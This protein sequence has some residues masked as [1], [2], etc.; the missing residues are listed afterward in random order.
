[1]TMEHEQIRRK[2]RQRLEINHEQVV[3][4]L[5]DSC[6][7]AP[8]TI[9]TLFAMI[10]Q[11][12]TPDRCPTDVCK[13]ARLFRIS[14]AYDD[15]LGYPTMLLL[16]PNQNR[17]EP[18]DAEFWGQAPG[19]NHLLNCAPTPMLMYETITISRLQPLP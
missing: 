9:S 12:L 15:A 18:A 14:S 8:P 17:T 10:R 2:C 19:M 7:T 1:M 6:N 16:V 11:S 13:C 4:V 5:E 3:R